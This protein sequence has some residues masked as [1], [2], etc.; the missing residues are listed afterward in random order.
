MTILLTTLHAKDVAA[1]T[2]MSAVLGELKATTPHERE[3]KESR[4]ADHGAFPDP[5][6]PAPA[7]KV[8]QLVLDGASTPMAVNDAAES[9]NY[10]QLTRERYRMRRGIEGRCALRHSLPTHHQRAGSFP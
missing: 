3:N 8:C 2:K 5:L 7:L 10:S 6:N 9:L 1:A 4:I